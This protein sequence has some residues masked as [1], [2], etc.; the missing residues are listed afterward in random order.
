MDSPSPANSTS[1]VPQ[2]V[3]EDYNEWIKSGDD[4][5]LS[6]L[7]AH[8]FASLEIENYAQVIAGKGD[9]AA[10]TTD[11][12][13]DSLTLAEVLFYTEDLLSIRIPNEDVAKLVTVGDL[14]KYLNAH[15]GECAAK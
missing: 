11:L 13:V 9:S 2:A 4:A 5:V 6:R 1:M 14:K 8:I 15:R 7:I 3:R 12:G 10:F